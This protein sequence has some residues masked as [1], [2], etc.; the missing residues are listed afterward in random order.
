M[1]PTPENI[2]VTRPTK[3]VYREGN[4]LIKLFVEG[5][6]GA[7]VFNEAHNIAIVEE[8]GFKINLHIPGFSL[9]VAGVIL[10]IFHHH[11]QYT[12]E[13]YDKK[14]YQ[15]SG[16]IERWRKADTGKQPFLPY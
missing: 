2:I 15:T 10:C 12:C 16:Y 5:Y 3:V 8:T 4:L 9:R 13:S 14:N 1:N 7:D 11:K 6:S